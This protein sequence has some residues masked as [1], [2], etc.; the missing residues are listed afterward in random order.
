[1]ANGGFG[2]GFGQAWS[3]SM[4][5]DREREEKERRRDRRNMMLMQIV[6]APIAQGL[7]QGITDAVKAPFKDPVNNFFQTE[8][9]LNL[10]S[11]VR[12][13]RSAQTAN[14]ENYKTL[15]KSDGQRGRVE[16]GV[17]EFNRQKELLDL[18]LSKL[19]GFEDVT[20]IPGRAE[21]VQKLYDGV[22]GEGGW[23]DEHNK[24]VRDL[25]ASFSDVTSLT[26]K[27][28][29]AAV[30][31]YNSEYNGLLEKG[32]RKIKRMF[33]RRTLED[34]RNDALLNI[35]SA[36]GLTE[37][38]LEGI[39]ENIL[40]KAAAANTTEELSKEIRKH[41]NAI[42]GRDDVRI[43]TERY[44]E[45]V[46][47][48]SKL[49]DSIGEDPTNSRLDFYYTLESRMKEGQLE[50]QPI[51]ERLFYS[52][53]S[54]E[55]QKQLSLPI[56]STQEKQWTG[57]IVGRDNNYKRTLVTYETYLRRLETDR[58]QT[59]PST[60][61]KQAREFSAS[62]WSTAR[63]IADKNIMSNS[64]LKNNI[65]GNG[66]DTSFRYNSYISDIATDLAN[67]HVYL[68]NDK[69]EVIPIPQ[70]PTAEG[71]LGGVELK[72]RVYLAIDTE[73]ENFKALESKYKDEWSMSNRVVGTGGTVGAVNG[74]VDGDV[75][76]SG[77]DNVNRPAKVVVPS[78]LTFD[79]IKDNKKIKD[80]FDAVTV[81]LSDAIEQGKDTGDYVGALEAY[82]TQLNRITSALT[83]A[84]GEPI[85]IQY[86]PDL[87]NKLDY[88]RTAAK[89][90]QRSR[91]TN[92]VTGG[93]GSYREPAVI[94]RMKELE[95]RKNRVD[96]G[97]M[98]QEDIDAI[99]N[100]SLMASP[101]KTT[102]TDSADVDDA[103][104]NTLLSTSE[105]DTKKSKKEIKNWIA[106]AEGQPRAAPMPAFKLLEKIFP[107]DDKGL[108]F[109]K[110]ISIVESNMGTD[111]GIY[112][113]QGG[114]TGDIGM[115]Q[116]NP[117]GYNLVMK[118]LKAKPG[119]KTPMKIQKYIPIVKDVVGL[120]LR[121]V[122]FEDLKD[123]RL[124][125][126]FGRLY[127]LTKTDEPIPDTLEGRA[128]YWKD[129]YNSNHPLA[130]GTP[131]RFVKAV[132]YFGDI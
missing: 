14:Q 39:D 7:T 118:R 22:F 32:F 46:E 74:N 62:V 76:G 132:E 80:V 97:D 103:Q 3:Q 58:K 2:Q 77:G 96:L 9:G 35:K 56:G 107:D 99:A 98:D 34:E 116:I 24:G 106:A 91:M 110:E 113:D 72:G 57:Q 79:M 117:I 83:S 92:V 38:N 69:G 27:R 119:D 88:L 41:F 93:P 30:D 64:D 127:L 124:N 122:E 13:Y 21:K 112:K 42:S 44:K 75:D 8:Q 48:K 71:L 53:L 129:H 4:R 114:N 23:L 5:M 126:I 108:Q 36:L 11:E 50:K 105:I 125:A 84:A 70:R 68:A 94:R 37:G 78:T 86:T 90:S 12:K 40:K 55:V 67:N 100:F 15:I 45:A 87:A 43:T 25:Y 120:D 101:T 31:K 47:F 89:N 1:M 123:N 54:K 28:V 95:A 73:T 61:R 121:N 66:T 26:D 18:E 109:L 59:T 82:D 29:K 16:F 52:E 19:H 17:P 6:G 128:Q 102:T 51:T 49:F 20:K 115:L 60:A 130:K 81:S 65:F 104:S 85:T 131:E 63:S 10:Q 111:E 33:S